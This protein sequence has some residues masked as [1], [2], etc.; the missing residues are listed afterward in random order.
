MK[1]HIDGLA[2]ELWA[3]AQLTPGEGITD[4]VDRIASI[5]RKQ[6]SLAF[7]AGFV[8]CAVAWTDRDD[9]TADVGSPAYIADREKSLEA[10]N[11]GFELYDS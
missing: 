8:M 1:K 10:L 11:N 5:L 9:L 2:H 7:D 6:M 3:A 4:G